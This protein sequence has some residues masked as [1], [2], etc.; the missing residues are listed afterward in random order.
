MLF[1]LSFNKSPDQ[2]AS[3]VFTSDTRLVG[4][5]RIYA[6]SP[7]QSLYLL[8]FFTIV[9]IMSAIRLQKKK[10]PW[11]FIYIYIMN[12]VITLCLIV[13]CYY[14]AA[15]VTCAA[16]NRRQPPCAILQYV[17]QLL[18]FS[19]IRH[20]LYCVIVIDPYVPIYIIKYICIYSDILLQLDKL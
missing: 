6:L 8:V 2:V 7:S 4:L 13:I 18:R 11:S 10:I 9:V 3:L 17:R 16:Y 1:T 15:T 19:I 5:Q 14:I 20:K 12:F